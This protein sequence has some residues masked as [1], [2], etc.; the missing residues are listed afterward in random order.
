MPTDIHAE[1]RAAAAALRAAGRPDAAD[2]LDRALLGSTSGEILTDLGKGVTSLLR[3]SPRL[4][5]E[6][7]GRLRAVRREVDRALGRAW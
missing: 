7:A 4:P 1:V 2:V 3:A 5:A 6:L